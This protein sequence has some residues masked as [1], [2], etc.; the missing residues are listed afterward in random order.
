MRFDGKT[1]LIT[2]AT[3]GF[4]SQT[5][6]RFSDLGARLVLSDLNDAPL[7]DLAQSLDADVA[8]LCGDVRKA[9]FHHQLVELAQ[10]T[11]GGLD[12]AVN[13]AGIVSPM[14]RIPD[15]DPE[16]AKT[17]LDVDLLG[18]F[19]ALQAQLPVMA[20]AFENKEQ[21]G[22]I[23]NIASA[24]GLVGSPFLGIYAAAKHGVV[25]LTRSAAAEYGRKNVR[26]NAIC[27][28]FAATTMLTDYLDASPK[29]REAAEMALTRG[30]PMA[31]IGAVDEVV[32]AILFA[33]SS[34]NSFMTGETLSVDGGLTAV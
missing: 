19:Y 28:S 3:G 34:A 31:R 8:T 17:V 32:E 20:A 26:V 29:G 2:G 24:A 16:F 22:A 30:I 21:Q 9:E 33:A 1:V 5:A 15:T 13:N 6:K 27:P 4:G 11:F 10:S 14:Q 7:N 25:G 12:I 23:V 18:V